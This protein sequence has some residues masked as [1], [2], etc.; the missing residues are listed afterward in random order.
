MALGKAEEYESDHIR[1]RGWGRVQLVNAKSGEIE[2]DSGWHG[3]EIT[4]TGYASYLTALLGATTGSIQ[5]T[6]LAVGT[7][8]DGPATTQTSISGEHGD[9]VTAARSVVA[10]QTMRMTAQWAT[11]EANV[12]VA[13]IGAY[14]TT[15]GGSI[16]NILTYA[17]TLKTTDQQLNGTIDFAFATS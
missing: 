1:I 7:Q 3:N 13:A 10:S 8:T 11:D 16:M 2:A 4:Q 17:S 15:S 5:A 12:S 6:V 14:N 9:R